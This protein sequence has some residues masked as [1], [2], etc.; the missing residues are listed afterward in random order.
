MRTILKTERLLLREF[1]IDDG[2]FIISLL[3][4]EDWLRF[5][6][7]R[8][9]RTAE[10]ATGY[11]QK[12]PLHSYKVHG[13]GLWA[14]TTLTDNALIGMCGLLKRDYLEHPDIG[15]AFLPGHQ[16]KGFGFEAADATLT[17]ASSTLQLSCVAA[18]TSKDNVRSIGLLEKLGF[19]FVELIH[20]EKKDEL[21]LFQT[22]FG[23][24]S[25]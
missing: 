4:S 25:A 16:G 8:N 6:G 2:P 9:V 12:G 22:C 3:N 11:L 23:S 7:D 19:Q 5:I 18:I 1:I 21:K 17:Y 14:V 15:F 13:F 24:K 10:D 20:T